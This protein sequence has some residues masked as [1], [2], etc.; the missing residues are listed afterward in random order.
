MGA[1]PPLTP[2]SYPLPDAHERP[3]RFQSGT[4]RILCPCHV[5]LHDR[6]LPRTAGRGFARPGR[7]RAA[8][9]PLLPMATATFRRSPV[10]LARVIGAPLISVANRCRACARDRRAPADRGPAG[11]ATPPRPT[12]APRG[13]TDRRPGRCRS[14]T[15]ARRAPA[16][17]SSGISF[18]S[19]IVR[20]E[21]HRVASSTP[22]ATSASVGHASRHLVH[23][24]H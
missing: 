9:S 8:G 15:R 4:D 22:G 24:P 14:R 1:A 10:S 7:A 3:L 13:C 17:A 23:A 6:V 19:S 11:P 21:R 20:Y 12:A 18:F 16:A 2:R 5:L